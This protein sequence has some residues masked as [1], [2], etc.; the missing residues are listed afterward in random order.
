MVISSASGNLSQR[1][2]IPAPFNLER[3][4]LLP[5]GCSIVGVAHKEVEDE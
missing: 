4:R 1:K 3:Q 5:N 2:L